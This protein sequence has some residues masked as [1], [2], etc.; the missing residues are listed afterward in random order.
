MSKMK[1]MKV[2]E[3]ASITHQGKTLKM[4]GEITIVWRPK[5][6]PKNKLRLNM[7][8]LL[9]PKLAKEKV[10]VIEDSS[11]EDKLDDSEGGNKGKKPI[12]SKGK[13]VM[14]NTKIFN[15]FLEVRNQMLQEQQQSEV[16][17]SCLEKKEIDQ[18]EVSCNTEKEEHPKFPVTSTELMNEDEEIYK[19]L[20]IPWTPEV[21]QTI[22]GDK[23]IDSE[24]ENLQRSIKQYK[25]QIEYMHEANDGLVT[26]NRILR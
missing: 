9:N 6:R 22:V 18:E 10:T 8:K 4:L 17:I 26:E 19:R 5:T 12:E 20:K 25:Y 11:S 24:K 13:S 7:K 1:K 16:K 15:I 14:T 23:C 3:F 21:M 2:V